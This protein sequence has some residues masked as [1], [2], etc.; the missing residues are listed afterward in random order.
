[1]IQLL[2]KRLFVQA[3]F[4]CL[5]ISFYFWISFNGLSGGFILDDRPN[6]DHLAQVKSYHDI[7]AFT[8]SG[9][10]DFPG[11]PLSYLSFAL[12]AEHWPHNPFPFK[13]MNLCIHIVNALLVYLFCWLLG[14]LLAWPLRSRLIFAGT[15]FCLWLFLPVHISTVFYVIQRMTLLAGLFTLLGVNTFL[16]GLLLSE[17]KPAKGFF[18]ASAGIGIAYIAGLL[19][20]E[21]AILVGLYVTVIYFILLRE[22]HQSK[23]WDCWIFLC[24]IL[25]TIIVFAYIF[26]SERYLNGYPIRNFTLPER[27]L[28]ESII[29]WEYVGKIFFPTPAKLNIFND[30]FPVSRSL[31]DPPLT[32][33]AIIGWFVA[34]ILAIKLRKKTA[35]VSFAI[36]WFLA[37]HLMESTF[38]AL[39]L[40]FEHRNYIP[41]LGLLMGMTGFII[42]Q[43]HKFESRQ[44]MT[45][46]KKIIYSSV[47]AALCFWFILVA[48]VEI[49]SW[50]SPGSLAISALTDRPNSLRARQVAAAFFANSKDY[51][52]SAFLLATIEQQWPGYPGTYAQMLMLECLDKHVITPNFNAI[53]DRFQHG[54]FDRGTSDAMHQILQFKKRGYCNNIPWAEYRNFL[55]IL[56]SNSRFAIYRE[57]FIVLLA[58]SYNAQK[59]YPLAAES[60]EKLPE[61]AGDINFMMLKARF[62]AMADNNKSALLI[63]DRIHKRYKDNFKIWTAYQQ[64]VEHIINLIEQKPS[65][66]S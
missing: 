37:G 56:L 55:N 12:Q 45:R 61:A 8:F 50:R 32:L 18:L 65:Q 51:P 22:S 11:R 44:S 29:V 39:E 7:W 43:W 6:L 28:T 36:C 10:T 4:L 26:F 52:R 58:Y 21:N 53:K 13:L 62:N 16:G 19:C 35:F 1:M 30:A 54:R 48:G 2:T 27:L 57:N 38:L 60:L 49:Q 25:P 14:Q 31:I 64:R 15:V 42:T 3:L 46:K 47:P 34:I 24:G 59:N 5:I 63:L 17:K 20:K 33:L 9:V 41:S 40:Y 66:T 23:L